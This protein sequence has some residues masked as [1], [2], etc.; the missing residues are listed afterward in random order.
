MRHSCLAIIMLIAA[1]ATAANA[2]SEK[3]NLAFNITGELKL[4]MPASQAR[5]LYV[6][7]Q[8]QQEHPSQGLLLI[9]RSE[10][11]AITNPSFHFSFPFSSKNI[12]PAL[13][14][15]FSVNLAQDKQGDKVTTYASSP[16]LTRGNPTN[17]YITIAPLS[18][19][20]E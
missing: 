12:D 6:Q 17:I 15:I 19:P 5:E 14:T 11:S 18:V 9:A 20:I 1:L 2:E 10:F 7:Y 16:V 4:L 8:L 3:D 13:M